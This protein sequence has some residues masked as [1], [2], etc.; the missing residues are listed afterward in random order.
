MRNFLAG[1]G[2]RERL[3]FFKWALLVRGEDGVYGWE[4]SID[5][6]RLWRR[7]VNHLGIDIHKCGECV[8]K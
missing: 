6:L 8:L 1:W 2:R 7:L 4:L 3:D 5:F